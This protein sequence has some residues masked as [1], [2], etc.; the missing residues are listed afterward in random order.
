MARLSFLKLDGG[1]FSLSWYLEGEQDLIR[2]Q[3]SWEMLKFKYG[4]RNP[5]DAGAV[6][7]IASRASRLNLFFQVTS[8]LR[9]CLLSPCHLLLLLL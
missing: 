6:E 4:L 8:C 1:R 9:L 2:D 3:R 7:P 5:L